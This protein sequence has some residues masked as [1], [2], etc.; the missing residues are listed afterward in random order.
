MGENGFHQLP[1]ALYG[2]VLLL[3]GLA[4]VLLERAIIANEG[5]DCDLARAVAQAPL[6][7]KLSPVAYAVGI[8]LAFVHPW[9]S[10][11]IYTA[12][13]ATWFIPD[14]RMERVHTR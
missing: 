2:V 8:A 5:P 10:Q 1:V 12:V 6:K 3:C 14:R 4:Y 7:E 9:L 11:L 13:A